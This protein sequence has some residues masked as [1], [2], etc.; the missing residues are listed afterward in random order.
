[1][2]IWKETSTWVFIA[3]WS[4]VS[5]FYWYYRYTKVVRLVSDPEFLMRALTI[6]KEWEE[7]D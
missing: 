6:L 7:N 4:T 3:A 5:S 1:M 2:A